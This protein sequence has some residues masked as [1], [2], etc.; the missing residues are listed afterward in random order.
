LAQDV[1]WVD[2]GSLVNLI[3]VWRAHR[4]DEVLHRCTAKFASHYPTWAYT[5][6]VEAI[7]AEMYETNRETWVSR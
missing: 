7:L 1:I 6:D 5:Y 3:A 4:L 2:R